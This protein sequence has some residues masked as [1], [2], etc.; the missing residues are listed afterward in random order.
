MKFPQLLT[1]VTDIVMSVFILIHFLKLFGI[2]INSLKCNCWDKWLRTL[3]FTLP[4][5]CQKFVQFYTPTSG[6]WVP[7]SPIFLSKQHS[8]EGEKKK[9]K[10]CIYSM[11]NKLAFKKQNKN[12]TKKSILKIIAN[13]IRRIVSFWNIIF[14]CLMFFIFIDKFYFC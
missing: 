3:R 5:C 2:R 7:N 12:K 4:N 6:L 14:T 10:L 9:V 13:L 1:S 11:K 8:G